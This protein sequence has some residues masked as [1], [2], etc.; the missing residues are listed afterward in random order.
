MGHP[1]DRHCFIVMP[2]GRD[3]SETEWYK[4]WYE[5]IIRPAV[6]A[7]GFKPVLAAATAAPVDITDEIREH[8]AFD[9]MA[10]VDLGGIDATAEPN[11]NVMYELGIRHALG[12]P[13]VLLAWK[14]QRLPFDVSHQRVLLTDRQF[15]YMRNT[16]SELRKFIAAARAGE[17]YRP[18]EVVRRVEELRSA[19]KVQGEPALENIATELRD[20]RGLVD[21]LAK[22]QVDRDGGALIDVIASLPPLVPKTRSDRATGRRRNSRLL[23]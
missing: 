13:L 14:G 20:I 8:L 3:Q 4:G 1:H 17:Y 7:E 2:F 9:P 21:G 11:P 23:R 18:M 16:R 19:A 12:L 15:L 22:S 5:Q 6:K 10:V